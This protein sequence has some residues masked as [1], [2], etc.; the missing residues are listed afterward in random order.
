MVEPSVARLLLAAARRDE[1]AFR[2]LFAL[3]AMND[4]VIGEMVPR[5]RTAG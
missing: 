4:A 3:L 2:A 5:N 1:Q